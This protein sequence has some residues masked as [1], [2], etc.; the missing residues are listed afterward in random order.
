LIRKNARAA[1]GICE[2]GNAAALNYV[3]GLLKKACIICRV[4]ENYLALIIYRFHNE[5]LQVWNLPESIRIPVNAGGFTSQ[6]YGN[7]KKKTQGA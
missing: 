4:S 7:R 6:F 3:L 5:H 1:P 2:T